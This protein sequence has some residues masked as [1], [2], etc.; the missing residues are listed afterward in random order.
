MS[1]Q[2]VGQGCCQK[3]GQKLPC[4]AIDF[5]SQ[6]VIICVV[7]DT[8]KTRRTTMEITTTNQIGTT[9]RTKSPIKTY[10]SNP[11]NFDAAAHA[12]AHYARKH[13]KNM[14]VV[15]GNSYGSKVYHI[16]LET[17]D[18]LKYS[19]AP[20]AA[21]ALVTIKGEVFQATATR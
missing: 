9:S 7:K 13:D 6:T 5:V 2:D 19:F 8:N 15:P 4:F 14:V 11:G 10:N 21:V 3:I 20:K 12:A 16:A 17:D 1:G 18:L